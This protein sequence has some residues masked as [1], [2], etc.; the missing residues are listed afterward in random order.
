MVLGGVVGAASC[1]ATAT[2]DVW[3]YNRENYMYDRKMRQK[4]ELQVMGFR[5]R[6]AELWRED[7]RDL[8][9]LTEKKMD[10]YMVVCTLALEFCITMLTEGRLEPGTPTWLLRF[11]LLTLCSALLYM[12]LAL[13]LAMHASVVAQGSC[14]RLLTQFVRLPIPTWDELEACRTYG[15]SFEAQ[16]VAEQLRVPFVQPLFEGQQISQAPVPA[17]PT[18]Q[19]ET[20]LGVAQSASGYVSHGS[21]AGSNAAAQE[22]VDPWKLERSGRDI[23]ELKPSPVAD[24]R[25]VELVRRAAV[26]YQSYDA[27]ARLSLSFGMN[28]LFLAIMYFCFGYVGIQDG[29]PLPATFVAIVM[30]AMI[31]LHLELDWTPTKDQQKVSYL[32]VLG[33]PCCTAIAIWSWI[34]WNVSGSLLTNAVLPFAYASHGLWL[35]WMIHTS[36]IVHLNNGSVLPLKF[37]AVL[38]LDVFGWMAK[39]RKQSGEEEVETGIDEERDVSS[40]V[41]L[42]SRFGGR[43]FGVLGRLG[44]RSDTY[45]SRAQAFPRQ[46]LNPDFAPARPEDADMCTESPI[47]ANL[48]NRFDPDRHRKGQKMHHFEPVIGVGGTHLPQANSG[49]FSPE[50]FFPYGGWKASDVKPPRTERTVSSHNHWKP[51]HTPAKVFQSLT[52]LICVLWGVSFVLSFDFLTGNRLE[53]KTQTLPEV[54]DSIVEAML[55]SRGQGGDKRQNPY[56]VYGADAGRNP[57]GARVY[58]QTPQLHVSPVMPMLQ[59]EPV[60]VEW[61]SKW[62]F[63][64]QFMSCDASGH[65]TVA[66]DVNLYAGHLRRVD[67]RQNASVG[68]DS[69]EAALP[70]GGQPVKGISFSSVVPC[71][72]LEGQSLT[73]VTMFCPANSSCRALV[74][75]GKHNHLVECSLRRSSLASMDAPQWLIAGAW[76]HKDE[77]VQSFGL[78]STCRSVMRDCVIVV[79]DSGRVVL[80]R[81]HMRKR[82]EFVPSRAVKRLPVGRTSLRLLEGGRVYL[83][84]HKSLQALHV[85]G[86]TVGEWSLPTGAD[87]LSHCSA[88]GHLYVLGRSGDLGAVIWQF[89]MPAELEASGDL[90]TEAV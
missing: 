82:Q 83:M 10:Y 60:H 89:P 8:V 5:V 61:P 73:D 43:L 74:L 29:A 36:G 53:F 80:L 45:S 79:T 32:L 47:E 35:W 38:Y 13:W 11:Y 51:G 28:Q 67:E 39:D 90:D 42:H 18:E 88:G 44:R 2:K 31:L 70:S 63:T 48:R 19:R 59:G 76:L 57:T 34:M 33:G 7:V 62:L 16:G 56:G 77:R 9:D 87:W 81:R 52:S 17:R 58:L 4:Q 71:R 1:V 50:N 64:P 68:A 6:Q 78:D 26:Y 20:R 12:L 27:F 66:D 65:F 3:D 86:H 46:I 14:A 41:P 22:A 37:R 49:A 15:A 21:V 55:Q 25:H 24:L 75:V 23:Y 72:G 85:D 30:V 40:T 54:E 69:L 84:L